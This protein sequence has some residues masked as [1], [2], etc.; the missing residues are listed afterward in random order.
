MREIKTPST[1]LACPPTCRRLAD[2]KGTRR[3]YGF[4]S[5]AA[6][7]QPI[8]SPMCLVDSRVQEAVAIFTV[9]LLLWLVL[10]LPDTAL[11]ESGQ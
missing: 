4:G 1:P 10:S 2:A 5:P 6:R 9:A 11:R 3:R 7:T 8:T